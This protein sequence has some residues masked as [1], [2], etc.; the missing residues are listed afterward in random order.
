SGAGGRSGHRSTLLPLVWRMLRNFASINRLTREFEAN[1]KL[2]YD[3]WSRI[4]F[5]ALKPHELMQLYSEF[6][7]RVLWSWRAPIINDFFVMIFYGSLKKLC[8]NWC[9]DASLQNDLLSG[10]G[11]IESAEPAKMLLRIADLARPH[12]GLREAIERG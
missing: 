7:D 10:E 6:E 5:G 3:R 9:K 1:F 11:G 4:D 12:Q 8:T 2:H